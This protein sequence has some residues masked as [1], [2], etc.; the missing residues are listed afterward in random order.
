[1]GDQRSLAEPTQPG[2][3]SEEKEKYAAIEDSLA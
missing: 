3:V 1:L 2:N